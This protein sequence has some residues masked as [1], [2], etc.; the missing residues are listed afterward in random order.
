MGVR[1]V[2]TRARVFMWWA[3]YRSWR[4][5]C[6]SRAQGERASEAVDGVPV[7]MDLQYR[8][9]EKSASAAISFA[10]WTRA[11]IGTLIRRQYGIKL[12]AI[13]WVDCWRKWG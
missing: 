12:S 6:A 1:L 11:M 5:G 7:E 4:M 9:I 13:S 10:L 3:A 8:D 2:F